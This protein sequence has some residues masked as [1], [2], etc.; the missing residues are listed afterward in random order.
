LRSLDPP[1]TAVSLTT[2]VFLLLTYRNT[3][4]MNP[5]INRPCCLLTANN[6]STLCRKNLIPSPNTTLVA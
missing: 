3:T 4:L 1:E 5:H 6:G 2:M